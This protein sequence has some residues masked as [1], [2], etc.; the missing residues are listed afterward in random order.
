MIYNELFFARFTGQ[1]STVQ[2]KDKRQLSFKKP[3]PRIEKG[4]G[5]NLHFNSDTGLVRLVPVISHL[6]GVRR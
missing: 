3:Y 2:M 1:L 4:Q 6:E 5:Y